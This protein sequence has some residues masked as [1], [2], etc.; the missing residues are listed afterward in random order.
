LPILKQ[1]ISL[2]LE[3]GAKKK[4]KRPSIGGRLLLFPGVPPPLQTIGEVAG[5]TTGAGTQCS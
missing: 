1:I 5:T 2:K 3:K 4:E